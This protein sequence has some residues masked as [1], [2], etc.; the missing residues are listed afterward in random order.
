MQSDDDKTQAVTVLSKGSVINHYRIVE[1]IGAGGMGEVYL[2]EDTELDRQVALKFLST[3]LCKDADCRARFK[4]E[5]RAAAKLSHPNIVTIYE[6]GESGDRPFFAME[7]VRGRLLKDILSDGPLAKER[8][9]EIIC[10]ICC[11]LGVAHEAGLVHRDIK[12]GNIVI[13]ENDRVRILDFGLAKSCRDDAGSQVGLTAGTISYMSPEQLTSGA[14][15]PASDL[16][17]L[18]I[19]FYE[20][21]TGALPFAGDYEAAI[22]YAI[23]NQPTPN[24]REIA[25]DL[26][27]HLCDIVGKM[28][29]KEPSERFHTAC[30]VQDALVCCREAQEERKPGVGYKGV[31]YIVAALTLVIA[32]AT[33]VPYLLQ[34][35]LVEPSP[36]KVLAVLPFENLGAPEDEYFANGTADAVATNLARLGDLTVISRGSTM[37]YRGSKKSPKAIG[38][39]LGAGYL[40]TGTIQWD[41]TQTPSRVRITT[42][43]VNAGQSNDIWAQSYDR[44]LDK[45]FAIQTDIGNDVGRALKVAMGGNTQANQSTQPTENLEAYDYYLRGNDYFNRSWELSDI[46]HATAMY[47]HAVELDSNFALAYAMLARGHASMYWEHF[48]RSEQRRQAAEQAA[49]RALV[50]QP[51]LPEA[52]VAQGYYYYHCHLDYDH[53]LQEFNLALTDAPSNAEIYNAI[54]AVERRQSQLEEAAQNFLKALELDP[55]SPLKA[56][57]VAL[58]YG[59]MRRF[60]LSDRYLQRA[61]SLAPDWALVH[62]YRAWLPIFEDGDA[63][64]S[65]RVLAEAGEQTDLQ[66]SNYYS[67]YYWWLLRNVEPDLHNVLAQ[68]RMGS[69]SAAYYLQVADLSR[70]LGQNA[71]MKTYAD[72]ARGVLERE[73]KQNAEDAQVQS[74]LGLCCA[75]LGNKDASLVH[76]GK[77]LQLLPS[78][79]DAFDAPYCIVNFAESEVIFG[80]YDSAIEHLKLLLS[81]PGF[82]TAQYLPLDPLWKPLHDKPEFQKLLKKGA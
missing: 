15:T 1:K 20:M 80:A 53:A 70:L 6:V 26:P 43:L 14:V 28:L 60:A 34:K 64:R 61:A 56:F 44:V 75:I 30:E 33:V 79:K 16:F 24:L 81:I 37:S 29:A 55:R 23:V 50:L 12:P 5:A 7:F 39:E 51:D 32:I 10:Q 42:T 67:K 72:S 73:V 11:G 25:A 62:I 22:L 54:A 69:D 78:S 63:V 47:Q 3:H 58:T 76:G 9:A 46:Q 48:D 27:E 35:R 2:A 57:D 68:V 49:T 13:D 74:Y 82:A 18:G 66:R 31:T 45:V 77:A 19:V 8:A 59:M 21:L 38:E 40:L 71:K 4:R 65:R 36:K 41:K 17:S 52:H